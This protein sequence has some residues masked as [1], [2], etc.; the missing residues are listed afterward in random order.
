M[1][2]GGANAMRLGRLCG[3]TLGGVMLIAAALAAGAFATTP[4]FLK[5]GGVTAPDGSQASGALDMPCAH[6]VFSGTLTVN[7]QP[8]DEAVFDAG[9][10]TDT[11]EGVL[12]RGDVK[13]IRLTSRGHFVLSTHLTW[14]VVTS[15]TCVYVIRKLAGTFTIP[16]PTTSK[17]SGTGKLAAKRSTAGCQEQVAIS[18]ASASLYHGETKE[19]YIAET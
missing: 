15:G 5:V 1:P 10:G 7:G 4:L 3:L 16:G 17:V 13:R 2:S 9:G 19:T 6:L 14:E 12:V 18:E 8:A 11:C